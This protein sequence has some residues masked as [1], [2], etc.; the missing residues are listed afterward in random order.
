MRFKPMVGNP[1]NLMRWCMGLA[2]VLAMDLCIKLVQEPLNMSRL[3]KC[4]LV[5]NCV[6][7][8]FPMWLKLDLG[9]F[10]V[11]VVGM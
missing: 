11:M 4:T 5:N 9:L 7:R 6:N 1:M 3:M 8:G 2:V 10:G